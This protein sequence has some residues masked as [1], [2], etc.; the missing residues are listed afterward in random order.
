MQTVTPEWSYII[1]VFGSIIISRVCVFVGALGKRTRY[2]QS[3]TA[4]L[5][6]K[7]TREE[8]GIDSSAGGCHSNETQVAKSESVQTPKVFFCTR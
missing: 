7:V 2:Q 6:L 5:L 8:S 1:S 3:E 4:Q